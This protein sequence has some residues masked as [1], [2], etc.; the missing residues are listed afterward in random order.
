M[1]MHWAKKSKLLVRIRAHRW[2]YRVHS[3]LLTPLSGP[4]DT[5]CVCDLLTAVWVS[6]R[7]RSLIVVAAQHAQQAPTSNQEGG[8]IGPKLV[9][10]GREEV[11]ELEDLSAGR[12]ACQCAP[13]GSRQ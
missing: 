10:E 13:E 12:A 8:T 6:F 11:D 9:P 7:K 1:V 2:R 3:W 4:K 5:K